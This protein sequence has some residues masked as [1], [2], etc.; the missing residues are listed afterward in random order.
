MLRSSRIK[1]DFFFLLVFFTID[2]AT[3]LH[4]P[5]VLFRLVSNGAMVEIS[6][7]DSSFPLVVLAFSLRSLY[8]RRLPSKETNISIISTFSIL[9]IVSIRSHFSLKLV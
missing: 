9:A 3:V 2:A 5:V 7:F 1:R 8:E 6:S 4:S